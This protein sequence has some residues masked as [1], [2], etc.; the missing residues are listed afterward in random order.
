MTSEA[1]LTI[2]FQDFWQCRTGS[3][4]AAALDSIVARD[5]VG[6]PIVPGK[7]IKGVLRDAVRQ[8]AYLGHF[9]PAWVDYL[10]GSAGF[11][12][13]FTAESGEIIQHPMS[14]TDPGLLSFSSA[15]VDRE[16]VDW[17]CS[18]RQADPVR[19]NSLVSTLFT[20]VAQTAI[21]EETGT[22]KDQ[23]LRVSEVVVPIEVS[24]LIS[25]LPRLHHD[26]DLP[27][28]SLKL[29][30]RQVLEKSFPLVE[31]FG[32][33]RTRGFGRAILSLKEVGGS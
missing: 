19:A 22:A 26:I 11:E 27:E 7:T 15:H 9:D 8:C 23:S 30:W 6:L 14:G 18:V 12:E 21:N 28:D 2:K 20:T 5:D 29:D 32:G 10:F 33:G 1:F 3:G 16:V 31:G 13:E 25:L 4:K 17:I 24:G